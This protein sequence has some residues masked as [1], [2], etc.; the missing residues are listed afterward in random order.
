MFQIQMIGNVIFVEI[1]IMLE[2]GDAIDVKKKN[3]K[4]Q[5]LNIPNDLIK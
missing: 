4:Q 3:H 2:E 5:C 1:S